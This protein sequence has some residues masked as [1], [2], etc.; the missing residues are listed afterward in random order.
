MYFQVSTRGEAEAT[1]LLKGDKAL[2]HL[3]EFNILQGLRPYSDKPFWLNLYYLCE[4]CCFFF[5]LKNASF[6]FWH[7][8]KLPELLRRVPLGVHS[9]G[10]W[11]NFV[12]QRWYIAMLVEVVCGFLSYV[13]TQTSN[14]HPLPDHHLLG[15]PVPPVSAKPGPRLT[16]LAPLAQ[17]QPRIPTSLSLAI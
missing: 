14:P 5:A 3:A 13:R 10:Q 1:S 4:K 17:S 7:T 12:E 15:G 8:N 11:L 2:Q 16:S 6:I 9:A